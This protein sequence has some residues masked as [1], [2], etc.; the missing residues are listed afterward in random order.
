[1]KKK[2]KNG[3]M[4]I[5]TSIRYLPKKPQSVNVSEG[6]SVGVDR[7]NPEIIMARIGPIDATPTRPK[8]S[9]S[10]R[11]SP[12]DSDTPN[13]NAIINGTAIGPWSHP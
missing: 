8:L 9:S 1:M 11:L 4:A 2:I 5:P 7:N 6:L 10:E 12:R 3:M 13:P